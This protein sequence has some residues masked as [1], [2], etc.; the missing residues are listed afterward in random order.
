MGRG[1]S[2]L[3]NAETV[4]Y[5]DVSGYGTTKVCKCDNCEDE[6][7]LY[8]ESELGG[9]CTECNCG[10]YVETEEYD[11]F[12]A[13]ETYADTIQYIQDTLTEKFP[14]L[15]EADEWEGREDHIIVNSG[16]VNVAVSEYCGL[17]AISVAC[18]YEYDFYDDRD[19]TGFADRMT[20]TVGAFVEKTLG[21]LKKVGGFSDGTS[22]YETA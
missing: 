22:V 6:L 12:I 18:A 4:V 3:N 17:M 10:N 2:Y 8:V 5:E 14:S 20:S 13:G 19:L 11:E 7:E 1:V 21:T 15:D 16:F 9:I